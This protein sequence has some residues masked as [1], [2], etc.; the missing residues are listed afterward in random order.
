MQC[1]EHI[2]ENMG[3]VPG[4]GAAHLGMTQSY[5]K[6]PGNRKENTLRAMQYARQSGFLSIVALGPALYS[7]DESKTS[8]NASSRWD[9]F[10][11]RLLIV[12]NINRVDAI[13]E[14]VSV[15]QV[16]IQLA[17]LDPSYAE[18]AV[19]WL[20]KGLKDLL[21]HEFAPAYVQAN[22]LLGDAC[23]LLAAQRKNSGNENLKRAINYYRKALMHLAPGTRSIAH[24]DILQS[25]A[26]VFTALYDGPASGRYLRYAQEC[27]FQIQALFSVYELPKKH[28]DVGRELGH[29]LC[30]QGNWGAAVQAYESAIAANGLLVNAM[31]FQADRIRESSRNYA[32][33][34]DACIAS[35]HAGLPHKA[36]VVLE[37]GKTHALADTTVALSE[38]PGTVTSAAWDEFMDKSSNLRKA[39]SDTWSIGSIQNASQGAIKAQLEAVR[40]AMKAFE[41]TLSEVR[42][43]DPEFLRDLN[44]DDILLALPD[45][46][47][48][49]ITFCFAQFGSI[50]LVCYLKSEEPQFATVEVSISLKDALQTLITDFRYGIDP[51]KKDYSEEGATTHLSSEDVLKQ[52][53]STFIA[54]IMEKLPSSIDSLT[55]LPVK[56]LNLLPLHAALISRQN[57]LVNVVEIYDTNYAPSAFTMKSALGSLK[58]RAKHEPTL[59]A[60]IDPTQDLEYALEEGEAIYNLWPE[61]NRALLSGEVARREVV[62]E[63]LNDYTYLHFACHGIYVPDNPLGSG[64]VMADGLI[65]SAEM[66]IKEANL[67]STRLVSLSA[68]DTGLV[69]VWQTSSE[70][71]GLATAFL[72]AGVPAVVAALWQVNDRATSLLMKRFYYNHLIESMSPAQALR[73][74][75]L[76][77]RD[78][79]RSEIGQELLSQIRKGQNTHLWR[80]CLDTLTKGTPDETPYSHPYYWAAFVLIALVTS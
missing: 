13:Y 30:E 62:L 25:M 33:Y 78:L 47:T 35:C 23:W 24:I 68:C 69:D 60:V 38:K 63:S 27:Y 19:P 70:Y 43:Q 41:G 75:Q 15:G 12:S 2:L 8:Q 42:Q 65:L 1:F 22:R 9:R 59:L 71:L 14:Y 50:A 76:W 3:T 52:L 7:F 48:A 74:A 54:P 37:K 26:K 28:I 49:I 36:F 67:S 31:Y 55:I 46:H 5:L 21:P 61:K 29:V 11:N 18:M 64:L 4:S 58:T 72:Q 17:E 66:I 53:G 32:I 44:I 77:L 51:F 20:E 16:L 6:L 34:E 39:W 57:Q 10:V 80:V 73:K 40:H 45:T 79:T 56:E